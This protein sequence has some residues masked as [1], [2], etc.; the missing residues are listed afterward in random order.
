M[1]S[2]KVGIVISSKSE[3]TIKVAI[4]TKFCDLKYFKGLVI[5]KYY[6]VNV[7]EG[8]CKPGDLIFFEQTKPVS[9]KKKWKFV[10]FFKKF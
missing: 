2:K 3:K 5:T 4:K 8:V 7:D 9:K 6:L 10:K 1:I